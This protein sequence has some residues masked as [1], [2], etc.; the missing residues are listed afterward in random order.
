MFQS[1]GLVNVDSE[2]DISW[3]NICKKRIPIDITPPAHAPANIIGLKLLCKLGLE[4][5]EDEFRFNSVPI[6]SIPRRAIVL[7]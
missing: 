3:I 6:F 4:L 2:T 7:T 5:Q 1:C